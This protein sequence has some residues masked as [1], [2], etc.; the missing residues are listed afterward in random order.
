[1]I[2]RTLADLLPRYLQTL[3]LLDVGASATQAALVQVLHLQHHPV[4]RARKE[5]GCAAATTQ[6]PG[7]LFSSG[8]SAHGSGFRGHCTRACSR[9]PVSQTSSAR[10]CACSFATCRQALQCSTALLLG[11][12][13]LHSSK[14]AGQ[15]HRRCTTASAGYYAKQTDQ[16]SVAPG[17]HV[18]A[19]R[20]QHAGSLRCMDAAWDETAG[21]RGAGPAAHGPFCAGSS[22]FSSTWQGTP[23]ASPRAAASACV[24]QAGAQ[25]SGRCACSPMTVAS[26]AA[27]LTDAGVCA[28]EPVAPGWLHSQTLFPDS[29]CASRASSLRCWSQP[30]TTSHGVEHP[31]PAGAADQAS[32]TSSEPM[33]AS[34]PR[35]CNVC[36]GQGGGT[37]VVR[38]ASST[39]F[40][41]SLTCSLL[42]RKGARGASW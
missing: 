31:E 27:G 4:R 36:P 30:G 8:R 12:T 3:L 13:G 11:Q 21:V 9:A 25:M 34:D 29:A 40:R 39:C 18:Q 33:H 16:T 32:R 17:R 28:H 20:A 1:M 41:I 38:S 7:R 10:A 19:S 22:R 24:A 37:M 42:H 26:V 15:V 23:R 6:L 2:V 5:H 35:A 14:A